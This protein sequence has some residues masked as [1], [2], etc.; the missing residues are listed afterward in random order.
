VTYIV[1]F[2]LYVIVEVLHLVSLARFNRILLVY[3]LSTMFGYYESHAHR[4]VIY[5]RYCKM[6][7]E[8][9]ES[10]VRS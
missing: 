3:P 10:I 8:I 7:I 1:R 9:I 2:G 6:Q 5:L 4:N